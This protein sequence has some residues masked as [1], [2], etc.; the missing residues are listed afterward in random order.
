MQRM[1]AASAA[2]VRR[3][4]AS[5]ELSERDREIGEPDGVAQDRA[6]EL[7]LCQQPHAAEVDGPVLARQRFG[8]RAQRRQADVGEAQVDDVVEDLGDR[9]VAV[10]HRRA[11]ADAGLPGI[12]HQSRDVFRERGV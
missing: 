8:G 6:T 11:G 7:A 3:R 9:Q 5:F 10:G 2:R 1:S 4:R 12:A